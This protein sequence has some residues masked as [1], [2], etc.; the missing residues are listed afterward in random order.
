MSKKKYY[1]LTIYSEGTA[2]GFVVDEETLKAFE[3]SFNQG[4]TS[5][6]FT[7]RDNE[8]AVVLRNQKLVGYQKLNLTP[9]QAQLLDP[10]EKS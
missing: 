3:D 4:E 7:N 8:A 10:E 5:I 6:H 9:E 1:N 2:P